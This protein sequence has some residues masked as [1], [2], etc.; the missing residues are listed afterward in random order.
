MKPGLPTWEAGLGAVGLWLASGP[1]SPSLV[2]MARDPGWSVLVMIPG[3]YALVR[4][5]DELCP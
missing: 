2:G 3:R 4:V 5:G 1:G